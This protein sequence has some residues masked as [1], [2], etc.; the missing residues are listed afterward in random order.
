MK[1]LIKRIL[2]FP[3]KAAALREKDAE[4]KRQAAT[5]K[6]AA[7]AAAE[8]M[9]ADLLPLQRQQEY[10]DFRLE[11]EYWASRAEKYFVLNCCGCRI[12]WERKLSTVE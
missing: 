5:A 12:L 6:A 2:L 7:K 10:W 8:E 11:E 9:A 3:T 1:E 4:R